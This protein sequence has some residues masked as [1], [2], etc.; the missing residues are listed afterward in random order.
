MLKI[1]QNI[2]IIETKLVKRSHRLEVKRLVVVFLKRFFC[3]K[4][5]LLFFIV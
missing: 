1:V 3:N 2:A 4:T 5:R